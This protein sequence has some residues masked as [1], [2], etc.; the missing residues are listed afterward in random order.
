M[1]ILFVYGTLMEARVFA[2]VTGTTPTMVPAKLCGYR[3]FAFLGE[4]YPGLV[5]GNRNDCV[6][7]R[8]IQDIPFDVWPR[9]DEYEGSL[10]ARKEVVV[11]VADGDQGNV[12]TC[13]AETYVV[14]TQ[15]KHKLSNHDWD[16]D[17][18]RK[19]HLERYLGRS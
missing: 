7:G 13:T 8:L 15:Y 5:T 14:K 16:F 4:C 19:H 6:I 10:Y 17:Y 18:F 11:E 3:R 9:L 12:E 2:A 1:P